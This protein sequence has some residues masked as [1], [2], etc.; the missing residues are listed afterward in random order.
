MSVL[1]TTLSKSSFRCQKPQT[2]SERVLSCLQP[3]PLCYVV[4]N[5]FVFQGACRDRS[6]TDSSQGLCGC[7]QLARAGQA[8]TSAGS[9]LSVPRRGRTRRG[10]TR[11]GRQAYRT[12]RRAASWMHILEIPFQVVSLLSPKTF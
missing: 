3:S 9:L 1:L 8:V 7:L 5:P 2:P 12:G 6:L 11:R 4:N 10:R